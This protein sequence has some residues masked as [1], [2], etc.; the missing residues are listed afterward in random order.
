MHVETSSFQGSSVGGWIALERNFDIWVI[1][2]ATGSADYSSSHVAR[3]S[4][5]VP[6][7]AVLI[8]GVLASIAEFDRRGLR[9]A[10]MPGL[11]KARARG[12]R[13][14]ADDP[15]RVGVSR[16]VTDSKAR[17]GCSIGGSVAS[18]KR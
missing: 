8:A 5:Q 17:A 16:P 14:A 18:I 4:I 10:S 9:S 2:S 11:A 12:K 15:L 7:P 3:A 6:R 1:D 13:S